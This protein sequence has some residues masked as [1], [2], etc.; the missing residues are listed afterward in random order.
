MKVLNKKAVER[1]MDY[2][3]LDYNAYIEDATM[4]AMSDG[5]MD[6]DF[7]YENGGIRI[8]FD[9]VKPTVYSYDEDGDIDQ[10]VE[11]AVYWIRRVEV[12]GNSIYYDV[13]AGN[14]V[15]AIN[16]S[17]KEGVKY[18]VLLEDVKRGTDEIG[19]C[20]P[21]IEEEFDELADAVARYESIDTMSEYRFRSRSEKKEGYLEKSLAAIADGDE[22]YAFLETETAGKHGEDSYNVYEIEK[23]NERQ[24]VS[25][26]VED[27][28]I[29]LRK[30]I[31]AENEGFEDV[32]EWESDREWD[33][34][35]LTDSEYE[36]LFDGVKVIDEK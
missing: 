32:E 7:S 13:F 2:M 4:Q 14:T 36:H 21:I 25:V 6:E 19:Y 15:A 5:K 1:V 22:V 23:D 29:I 35:Y 8:L 28:V 17:K 34:C 9:C 12:G 26:E 11:D 31:P 10:A 16:I 30:H 3:M 27:G 33:D 18:K 20:A 24:F